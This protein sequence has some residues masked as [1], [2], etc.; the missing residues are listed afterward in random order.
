MTKPTFKI[1]QDVEDEIEF[2]V[3]G[4]LV[5]TADH[6]EHGWSGMEATQ[7]LFKSIAAELGCEVEE[8]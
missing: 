1:V 8:E 5:G 3:N 7:R 4:N 2:Y 6:D